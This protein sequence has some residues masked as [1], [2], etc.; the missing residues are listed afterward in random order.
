MPRLHFVH[1]DGSAQ[2]VEAEPGESVM[3]VAT[4]QQVAGIVGECGGCCS[5]A[6]CHVYVDSPWFEAL[7]A[8]DEME[9]MMLEAAVEPTAHSRLCCQITVA[10]D[11]DGMVLRIPA[12][13]L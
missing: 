5:C 12:G 9:V 7:A 8:P 2:A 10:D 1:P 3:T 4:Q 13:Q 6:T 11:L